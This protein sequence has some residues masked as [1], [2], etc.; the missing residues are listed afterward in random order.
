MSGWAVRRHREGARHHKVDP[1]LVG[2]HDNMKSAGSGFPLP[3]PS[4]KGTVVYREYTRAAQSMVRRGE[5]G[6][7][8][9]R[10]FVLVWIGRPRT[11]PV[12]PPRGSASKELMTPNE[13]GDLRNRPRERPAQR[14]RSGGTRRSRWRASQPRPCGPELGSPMRRRLPSIRTGG[15]SSPGR[16][17]HN[18]LHAGDSLPICF[19]LSSF[20]L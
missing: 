19:L 5:P 7:L 9:V 11:S 13:S 14:G 8:A 16:I 2:D 17:P 6:S 3:S 18:R 10:R 12:R 4:R 20:H 1:A 15:T